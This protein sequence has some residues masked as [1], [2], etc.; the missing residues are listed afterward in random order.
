[1]GLRRATWLTI[2]SFREWFQTFLAWVV[3]SFPVTPSRERHSQSYSQTSAA[4]R[5]SS[6]L[7]GTTKRGMRSDSNL[8]L[9]TFW[10]VEISYNLK[11]CRKSHDREAALCSQ[12][13]HQASESRVRS[14]P[15]LPTS[16]YAWYSSYARRNPREQY[17]Q[18]KPIPSRSH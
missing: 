11:P 18:P 4:A 12:H 17:Q 1:M 13:L 6:I 5:V 9:H 3:C 16:P 7:R 14:Q 15:P 8:E 2:Q 10:I